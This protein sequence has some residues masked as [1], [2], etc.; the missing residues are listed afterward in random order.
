MPFWQ[1]HSLCCEH[2]RIAIHWNWITQIRLGRPHKHLIIS[3]QF[4]A[5]QTHQETWPVRQ[6]HQ[7]QFCWLLL[8][9]PHS[10]L[11]LMLLFLPHS[12]LKH[13]RVLLQGP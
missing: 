7:W 1:I 4:S 2:S 8:L 9:L 3:I 11:K 10:R 6:Q 5:Q 12:R 13:T